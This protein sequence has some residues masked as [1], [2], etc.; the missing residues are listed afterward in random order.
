MYVGKYPIPSLQ[1]LPN[2]QKKATFHLPPRKPLRK[3]ILEHYFTTQ[4]KNVTDLQKL[5]ADGAQLSAITARH[6][7]RGDCGGSRSSLENPRAVAFDNETTLTDL[8][9]A[10][11]PRTRNFSPRTKSPGGLRDALVPS[12]CC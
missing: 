9:A 6:A 10:A 7:N 1:V 3:L 2:S 5:H 11:T 12:H 4:N 8:E